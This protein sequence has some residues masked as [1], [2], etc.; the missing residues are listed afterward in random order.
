VVAH[1]FSRRA[2]LDDEP[3]YP[4]NTAADRVTLRAYRELAALEQGVTFGGRLGS[5]QY[6]DMHMAVASAL[7]E[8]GRFN[9]AR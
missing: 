8:S 2:G 5:Y 6:L 3:Y 9:S 1:E 7:T 4:V